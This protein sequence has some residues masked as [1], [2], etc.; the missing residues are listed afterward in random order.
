[1]Y[2]LDQEKHQYANGISG[3]FGINI[4]QEGI[5]GNGDQTADGREFAKCTHIWRRVLEFLSGE[6]ER[7]FMSR[8]ARAIM[9]LSSYTLLAP[10]GDNTIAW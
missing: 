6:N 3:S 2:S 10:M 5:S 4:Q 1:M 8:A 7:S 9:I